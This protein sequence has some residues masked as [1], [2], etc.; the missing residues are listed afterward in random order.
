[1]ADG[2]SQGDSPSG[3]WMG[4][5]GDQGGNLMSLDLRSESPNS[6]MYLDNFDCILFAVLNAEVPSCA[7]SDFV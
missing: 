1:M 2:K 5:L 4:C 3:C 6:W 7:C